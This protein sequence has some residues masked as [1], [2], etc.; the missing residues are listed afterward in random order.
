VVL[1]LGSN[2]GNP[3]ENLKTAIE[4]LCANQMF[5]NFEVASLYKTAPVGYTEQADFFNTCVS[6]DTDMAPEDLLDFT[7]SIEQALH[8]VRDIRWGPRTLDIDIVLYGD[9]AV[10]TKRLT[11]PHPR[12]KERAFVVLPLNEL[13][14]MNLPVP[15]G[16]RADVVSWDDK[17]QV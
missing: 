2:M 10:D 16:Q 3:R 11:I 15:E 17:A 6:F 9:L 7:Q 13:T 12:Y 4:M 8:R 14:G 1:S 5:S